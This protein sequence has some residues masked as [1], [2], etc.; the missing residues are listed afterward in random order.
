[1]RF[2]REAVPERRD[3]NARGKARLGEIGVHDLHEVP[4][5]LPRFRHSARSGD[6]GPRTVFKSERG[7]GAVDGGAFACRSRRC[8]LISR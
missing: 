2:V 3:R 1:M 4:A 8:G 7:A 5:Q 6:T